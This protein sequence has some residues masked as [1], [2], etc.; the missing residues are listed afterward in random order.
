MQIVVDVISVE[1]LDCVAPFLQPSAESVW[2]VALFG[3]KR[4]AKQA[5]VFS[6]PK[7]RCH[8]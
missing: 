3:P 6:H 5:S 2:L 4:H 8:I 7:L 1:T